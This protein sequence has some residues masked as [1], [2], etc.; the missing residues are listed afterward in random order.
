MGYDSNGIAIVWPVVNYPEYS[1]DSRID[2]P[3]VTIA[4]LGTTDI[5]WPDKSDITD[6]FRKANIGQYY[7]SLPVELGDFA[8]FGDESSPVDVIL[9]DP[10][11]VGI[12]RLF[13]KAFLGEVGLTDVSE[14]EYTAH[15]TLGPVGS[16]DIYDVPNIISLES[17]VLWY[18]DDIIK[19]ES[20]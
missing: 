19:A 8:V 12:Y 7:P 10:R 9:V 6:R 15:M 16:K 2:Y 13:I 3:H 20:E 4:Y 17:P 18:G 11:I 5:N 1:V 14:W